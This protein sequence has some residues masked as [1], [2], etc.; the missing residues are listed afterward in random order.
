[1][2]KQEENKKKP[3]ENGEK[4][5]ER[6]DKGRFVDGNPGGP[7][8]TEGTLSITSEIKKKLEQ[9]PNK[10]K[11]KSNLILLIEVILDKAIKEKDPQTIKQ[12]WNYIDGM[13]KQDL[14]VEHKIPDNLIELLKNA[15]KSN[16]S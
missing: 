8:R 11:K 16:E 2:E 6:D 4:P 15:I 7:G 1:M 14:G 5:K 12:I 3:N 9:I 10:K 13:P